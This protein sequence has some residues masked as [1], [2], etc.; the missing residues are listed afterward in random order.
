MMAISTFARRFGSRQSLLQDAACTTCWARSA[1]SRR[2]AFR[3]AVGRQFEILGFLLQGYGIAETCGAPACTKDNVMGSVGKPL[4]NEMKIFDDPEH[5]GASVG[6]VA[7]RGGIIM[8]GYYKRPVSLPPCTR[9]ARSGD[10]GYCDAGGSFFITGRKEMSLSLFGRTSTTEIEAHYL[11]SP[12]IRRFA[13]WGCRRA[14]R[15]IFRAPHAVIVPDFDARARSSRRNMLRFE[16]EASAKLRYQAHLSY[17][18]VERPACTTT[19][20]IK[21]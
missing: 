7:F 16:I 12:S 20:K 2:L 9:L 1:S 3:S 11:Q 6:E 15:T 5:G 18:S 21:R 10:L 14:R 8:A 17:Q 13:F 19:H 4:R